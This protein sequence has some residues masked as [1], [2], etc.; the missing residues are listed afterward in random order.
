MYLS[1]ESI[2]LIVDVQP[3]TVKGEE[4]KIITEQIVELVDYKWYNIFAAK[5]YS[6]EYSTFHMARGVILSEEE[7]GPTDKRIEEKLTLPTFKKQSPSSF[8]NGNLASILEKEK[9]NGKKI[10]VVGFDYDDCVLSTV[11]DGHSRNLRIFAINELCGNT[12]RRGPIDPK[13]I[14]S[15]KLLL[16]SAFCLESIKNIELVK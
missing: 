15:A 2:L 11:L 7:A 4:A 13:L 16:K 10:F 8:T 12:E 14:P 9:V 5:W 6:D 3:N 1:S